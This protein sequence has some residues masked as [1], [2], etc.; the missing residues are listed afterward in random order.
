MARKPIIALLAAAC[1]LFVIPASAS[2]SGSWDRLLAPE[3]A[4]PGQSDGSLPRPVQV[5]AMICMHNWARSQEQL[6]G[7]SVSKQLRASSNRKAH[8]IKRCGQF[9]H[10]ACGRNPFYWEQRAGFLRGTYGVG[11]NLAFTTGTNNTV[12]EAMDLWLNSTEHR[13]NLL[14][15]QYRQVGISLVTGRF[16]GNRDAHIWVAQFGYHH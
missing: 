11:E 8:D 1:A 9:S 16:R 15:P 7:L 3:S 14:A 5:Q 13:Q 10:Y 12:R 6:S 4:C 2:A